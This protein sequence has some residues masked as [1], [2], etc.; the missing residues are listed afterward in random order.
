MYFNANKNLKERARSL[1]QSG[2]LSEA[3]LWRQLRNKQ[4][5]GLRFTRQNIIG[6][7]I[8]DFY[9][10]PARVVVEIDGESHNDKIEYD[11]RRDAYFE[12]L[13]LTVIHILDIDVKRN[14]DSVMQMLFEHPS[15]QPK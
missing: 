14:L 1:R 5:N 4:L 12:K 13:G 6:N 8:A 2:N 9:C 10:A 11:Q 15:L 3:L 7:F